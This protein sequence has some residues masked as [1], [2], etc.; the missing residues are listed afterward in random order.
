MDGWTGEW[1][2][3]KR[4]R[5]GEERERGKPEDEDSGALWEARLFS[6]ASGQPP[7][8]ARRALQSEALG[9]EDH[10]ELGGMGARVGH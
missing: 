7:Q 2:S 1:Q 10:Q 4:P 3:E 8:T 9:A 5:E 6:L